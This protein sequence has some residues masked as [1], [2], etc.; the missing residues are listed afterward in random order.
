[1]KTATILILAVAVLGMGCSRTPYVDMSKLDDDQ[2]V[3][4]TALFR[5]FE[6]R[7]E[8]RVKEVTSILASQKTARDTTAYVLI[9]TIEQRDSDL[10]EHPNRYLVAVE[11]HTMRSILDEPFAKKAVSNIF[12]EAK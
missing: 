2:K 9:K 10:H 7:S 12:P 1:M 8:L 3:A 4:V 6:K 5:Q 11:N